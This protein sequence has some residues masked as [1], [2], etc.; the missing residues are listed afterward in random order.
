M[1]IAVAAFFVGQTAGLVFVFAYVIT[2]AHLAGIPTRTLIK[3][4]KGISVFVFLIIAV[5]AVLVSGESLAPGLP[6]PTREG[7]TSG[8]HSAVRCRT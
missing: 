1:F 7:I 4:G 8:V 5:N 6:F 2:L 3:N